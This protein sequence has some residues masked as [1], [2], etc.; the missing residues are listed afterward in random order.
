MKQAQEVKSLGKKQKENHL[1]LYFNNSIAKHVTSQ[2]HLRVLLDT[3]LNFI[4]TKHHLEDMS[5]KKNKLDR[6]LM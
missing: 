2:K 3:K 5:N 6:V 1:P 4:E